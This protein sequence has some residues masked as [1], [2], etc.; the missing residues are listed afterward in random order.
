MVEQYCGYERTG[1]I[2]SNPGQAEEVRYRYNYSDTNLNTS[3][4]TTFTD[5]LKRITASCKSIRSNGLTCSD[6]YQFIEPFYLN[7]NPTY[8]LCR[9]PSSNNEN[10]VCLLSIKN[11]VTHYC[12]GT[13]DFHI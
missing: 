13:S 11:E 1:I 5:Q 6:Y 2:V 9:N 10:S 4:C 7:D 3:R 8:R 12:N